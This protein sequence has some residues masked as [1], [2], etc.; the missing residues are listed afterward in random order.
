MS[1]NSGLTEEASLRAAQRGLLV[2]Q[3]ADLAVA[4]AER[5]ARSDATRLQVVNDELYRANGRN[6]RLLSQEAN[7]VR[8][9]EARACAAESSMRELQR[10][11]QHMQSVR[12]GEACGEAIRTFE[13]DCLRMSEETASMEARME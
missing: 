1:A 9:Y 7:E 8:E 12:F 4:E 2:Q 13:E 3:S 10:D 5:R 11:L 6:L